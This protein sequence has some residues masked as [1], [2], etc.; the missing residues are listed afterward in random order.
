MT[1]PCR[2]QKLC[3]VRMSPWNER[4][5]SSD[6][7][8]C[9]GVATLS[10]GHGRVELWKVQIGRADPSEAGRAGQRGARFLLSAPARVAPIDQ[11]LAAMDRLR[12]RREGA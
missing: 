10:G 5:G 9:C 6:A 4:V 3:N 7:S 8:V 1:Q 12:Q 2:A 11:G